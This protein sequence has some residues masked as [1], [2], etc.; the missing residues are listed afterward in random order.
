MLEVETD[1][2]QID[3]NFYQL[4][5]TVDA[6]K[7]SAHRAVK[8]MEPYYLRRSL[9][10]YLNTQSQPDSTI[11]NARLGLSD[12]VR[13][14][15]KASIAKSQDWRWPGLI[16][17]PGLEDFV[18]GM[19]AMDPLYLV[20]HN[21]NL[22][23]PALERFPPLFQQRTACYTISEQPGKPILA[24]LPRAQMGLCVLF[25][26]LN[27]RPIEL[28]QQW[29]DELWA[30]VRPGGRVLFTYND[31]DRAHGVSMYESG[32]MSYTPG[33]MIR[34]HAQSLGFEIVDDYHPEVGVDWMELR[35]PGLLTSLKASQT[36]A[37][38][39]ARSK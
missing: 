6:L 26:H 15:I 8:N 4:I 28:V 22:L 13:E 32:F 25:Y 35:R 20:D 2:A 19:T 16:V 37:K 23:A 38:V 1:I 30:V 14:Y 21:L 29:L 36:L 9:H 12:P 3:Q 7:S 27:F 11:L 39:V 18:T 34:G 5:K 17:R 10:Q 33:H 31:C 24:D